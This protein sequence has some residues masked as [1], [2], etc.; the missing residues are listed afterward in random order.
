MDKVTMYDCAEQDK[1]STEINYNITVNN[2]AFEFESPKAK[3]F[4]EGILQIGQVP[5]IVLMKV[6]VGTPTFYYANPNI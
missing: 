5:G 3:H 2:V 6:F 1:Y 4:E